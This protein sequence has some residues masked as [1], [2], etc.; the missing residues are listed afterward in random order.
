MN[1]IAD[2]TVREGDVSSEFLENA[3]IN[4]DRFSDLIAFI[5]NSDSANNCFIAGDDDIVILVHDD[6]TGTSHEHPIPYP[7]LFF[8]TIFVC[9]HQKKLLNFAGEGWYNFGDWFLHCTYENNTGC[10]PSVIGNLLEV[11]PGV[12]V[13]TN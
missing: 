6:T 8:F 5:D 11:I 13:N 12:L 10:T 3:L 7:E 2:Y 1:F 4:G 9:N